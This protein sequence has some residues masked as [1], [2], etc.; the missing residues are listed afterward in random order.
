MISIMRVINDRVE[1]PI[2]S[3]FLYSSEKDKTY[4]RLFE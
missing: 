3:Y 2:I 4:E 1:N